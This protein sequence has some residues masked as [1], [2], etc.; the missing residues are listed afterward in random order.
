MSSKHVE[1]AQEFKRRARTA[2]HVRI[3]FIPAA[4]TTIP[5]SF[6][7][8][9]MSASEH[10]QRECL[11]YFYAILY[12]FVPGQRYLSSRRR[13]EHKH[14]RYKIGKNTK[15]WCLRARVHA[16]TFQLSQWVQ[17]TLRRRASNASTLGIFL[18]WTGQERQANTVCHQPH[19]ARAAYTFKRRQHNI[20]LADIPSAYCAAGTNL[21]PCFA[22]W[23]A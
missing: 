16:P 6:R 19:P 21:S 10:D 18:L 9:T 20:H 5:K 17:C 8:L 11:Y 1:N 7:T 23:P 4:T 2:L 15:L 22:S 12:V 3:I 13:A 14:Q